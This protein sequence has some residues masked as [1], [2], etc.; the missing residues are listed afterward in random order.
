MNKELRNGLTIVGQA[1]EQ[2]TSA[3]MTFALPIGAACDPLGQSGAA[4]VAAEWLFRGAADRTSRELNDALDALGCRHSE[5][6]Q[7]EHIQCSTAQ[8]GRN[9]PAVLE[10]YADILR[11]PRLEENSFE[12]CRRLILQD[13]LSFQDEPSRMCM[14]QLR[15]NF[16]PFPLGRNVYGR[17]EDLQSMSAE[18]LRTYLCES[19]GPRGLIVGVA[20]NFDWLAFCD[21]VEQYFGDWSGEAS[22][23]PQTDPPAG[24]VTHLQKDT[25]QAHIGIAQPAVP[26]DHEHYYPARIAESVLSRGMG[27]RLITEVREK[28]GLVY[29]V[30]ASYTSLKDQAGLF[31]YAGTRPEVARQTFEVTVGELRRLGEGIEEEELARAK[32]QMRS[33]LVM[34]GEST[35]ARANTLCSDWFHLGR[36]RSLDEISS[37]ILQV[38]VRDVLDYWHAWPPEAF[39]VVTVGPEPVVTAEEVA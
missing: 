11:R 23:A 38:R 22:P 34:Q 14:M 15:E 5:S 31:A 19:L 2:M 17:A 6:V 9:L 16:F 28:R 21:L 39:T 1:M 25:A 37:G 26:C 36:L 30:S 33:A 24:G 29:H 8:L 20:G 10:L 12:P 7:S 13:L 4:S 27:S 3:A 35:L 18:S 32:T